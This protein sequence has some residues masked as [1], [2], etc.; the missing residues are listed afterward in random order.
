MIIGLIIVLGGA[1]ILFN[2]PSYFRGFV[3]PPVAGILM[4]VAG[5]CYIFVNLFIRVKKKIR[6]TKRNRSH[7][8]VCIVW[9]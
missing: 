9:I 1:D 4:I 8:S 7:L 2:R 6:R 5:S 3:V